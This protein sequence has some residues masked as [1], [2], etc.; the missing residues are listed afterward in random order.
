MPILIAR[1]LLG[2]LPVL[3]GVTF[4]SFL[5]LYVVPGDPVQAVA[6][7]RYHDTLLAEL[8]AALHLDDPPLL[9]YGHFLGGLLRRDLGNSYVTRAPVS[10]PIAATLP[11]LFA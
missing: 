8:R 2:A 4:L 11:K 10:E 5:L 1:R 7:E 6:G 3:L 9:R